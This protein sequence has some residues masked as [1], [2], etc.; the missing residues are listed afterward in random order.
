MPV[1]RTLLIMT[2]ALG[3][4]LL[5]PRFALAAEHTIAITHMELEEINEELRVGDVVTFVNKADMAH[6]LYIT[7]ADGSVDNL[8]TQTPGMKRTVTLK[9][10]G[11]AVIKCWI[12]PIIRTDVEIL[13]RAE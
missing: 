11:P 1:L 4:C 7:Y 12:H 5:G 9:H 13:D 6:N 3:A 8:D 10:A 2:M